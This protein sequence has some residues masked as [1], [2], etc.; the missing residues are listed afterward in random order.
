VTKHLTITEA[1]DLA[2]DVAAP[3]ARRRM[4]QH[5]STGCARCG[6]AVALFRRVA[7]MAREDE[8]WEPPVETIERAENIFAIP[9][10]ARVEK[11]GAVRQLVARLVFDSFRE[12][13]PAGM[14]SAQSASRHVLYKAGPY[15]VDLRLDA[16][17]GTRRVSVAGQV[18]R[19]GGDKTQPETVSVL[20]IDQRTVLADAPV[21]AL[22]EFHLDYDAQARLR[23]RVVLNSGK[24]GL[25]L[26]LARLTR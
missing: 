26:P 6:E 10:R 2:R 1:A 12:P 8:R 24:A 25:D 23:L 5:I 16:T 17:P 11:E 9:P 3:Q 21:N 20:L 18:V 13:L 15:F 22:G 19:R 14:R 7:T 4:E